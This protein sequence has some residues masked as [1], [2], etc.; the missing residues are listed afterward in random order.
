MANTTKLPVKKKTDIGLDNSSCKVLFE[1][2]DLVCQSFLVKGINSNM[3]TTDDH[4]IRYEMD[5]ET[6]FSNT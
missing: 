6:I 3:N 1:K 5:I 2:P 4:L